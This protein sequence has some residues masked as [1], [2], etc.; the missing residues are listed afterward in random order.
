MNQKLAV[1]ENEALFSGICTLYLEPL[2]NLKS[3]LKTYNSG[4]SDVNY[5]EELG[6]VLDHFNQL[7]SRPQTPEKTIVEFKKK[8]ISVNSEFDCVKMENYQLKG[9]LGDTQEKE[10][11]M[12]K[13]LF[14]YTT[15][16]LI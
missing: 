8:Q 14:L 1:F 13:R 3:A 16:L 12:L 6:R 2:N 4:S 10:R 11:R 5:E 9:N 7:T 15:R